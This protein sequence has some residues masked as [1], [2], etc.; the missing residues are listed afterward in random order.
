M[1]FEKKFLFGPDPRVP[2]AEK[3]VLNP[4]MFRDPDE[5]ETI[6]MLFRATGAMAECRIPGKKL[7]YP[8]FLG[9]AV[10]RDNGG[11][12]ECDWCGDFGALSSLR[13]A[14]RAKLIRAKN[15]SQQVE[16]LATVSDRTRPEAKK[17]SATEDT[18]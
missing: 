18:V 2:W 17:S 6:H 10:S 4:A 3:M 12:W 7:P 11:R 8:I 13:P 9:Y 16:F 15:Q 14:E 5:P 1:K